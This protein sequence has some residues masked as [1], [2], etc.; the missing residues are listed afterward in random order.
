MEDVER[1]SNGQFAPGASGSRQGGRKRKTAAT[2]A[3]D[4]LLEE[5]QGAVSTREGKKISKAR[6]TARQI[7][8]EGATGKNAR[9]ALTTL[10]KAEERARANAAP[11]PILRE[12]DQA[13][14]DAFVA[15]VRKTMADESASAQQGSADD[16]PG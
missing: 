16:S 6:A 3:D 7:A 2:T 4:I 14:F 12:T 11:L 9:Q 8:N 5:F 1:R 10:Q 13:I 15:L